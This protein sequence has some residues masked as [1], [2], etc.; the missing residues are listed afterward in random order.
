MVFVDVLEVAH[1]RGCRDLQTAG[2]REQEYF[3]SF[4]LV[5]FFIKKHDRSP[6]S[7]S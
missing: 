2:C 7:L 4:F 3:V 5:K 6:I 1:C